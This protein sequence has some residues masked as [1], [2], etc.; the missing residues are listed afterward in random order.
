MLGFMNQ[1]ADLD[2][3]NLVDSSLFMEHWAAFSGACG[4]RPISLVSAGV[5][6]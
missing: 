3:S 5:E 6:V 1:Q 4:W 2:I